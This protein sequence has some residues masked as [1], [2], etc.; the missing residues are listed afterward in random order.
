MLHPEIKQDL[1]S[2]W[3]QATAKIDIFDWLRLTHNLNL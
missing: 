3:V 1:P 2:P